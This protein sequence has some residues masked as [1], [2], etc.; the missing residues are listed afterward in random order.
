MLEAFKRVESLAGGNP[1]FRGTRGEF[2]LV[3]QPDQ[4]FKLI[5]DRMDP[6]ATQREGHNVYMARGRVESAPQGWWRPGMGGTAKL[7]AGDRSLIW[8]LT[9]RTVRFLR[10]VFWL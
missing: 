4:K 8:V 6:A 9:H 5:I 7:E 3:G 10:Q 2:A 1:A